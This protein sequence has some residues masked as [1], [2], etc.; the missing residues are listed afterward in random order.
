VPS[1]ARVQPGQQRPLPVQQA[2][3]RRV[4]PLLSPVG[5]DDQHAPLIP[6]VGLA[7]DEPLGRQ[8]VDPVRHGAGGDQRGPEQRARRELER[9]AL[10][11]QRREHVEGP[12]LELVLGERP[13]PRD[14]QVPGQPGDPAEHLH[15]LHVQIG[16]LR[17]PRGDQVVHLVSQQRLG[18]DP[19]VGVRNIARGDASAIPRGDSI[20]PDPPGRPPRIGD[21]GAGALT[22][23]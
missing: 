13:A 11:A 22:H 17:L 6:G 23:Y 21:A 16:P 5:E 20:P 1:L 3:Q 19:V 7:A 2:G 12:R 9:R 15:R 4:H 14:V 18:E 8:P 10:P